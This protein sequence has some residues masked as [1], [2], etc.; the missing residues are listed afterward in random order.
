MTDPVLRNSKA[1]MSKDPDLTISPYPD[2][3]KHAEFRDWLQDHRST[4][5]HCLVFH[6]LKAHWE[7]CAVRPAIKVTDGSMMRLN[8]EWVKA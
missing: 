8:H 4:C 7:A 2:P 3:M 6:T 5:R 1:Y